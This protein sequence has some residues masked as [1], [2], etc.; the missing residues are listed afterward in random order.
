[1][2]DRYTIRYF[3]AVIDHGNFSKAAAHCHVSQPTLSVG[4]AKLERHLGQTLFQRSNRRVELTVAGARFAVHA[5]RVEAEFNHAERSVREVAS[6]VTIRLGILSTIPTRWHEALVE[7]L[8][9][10]VSTER[11]E[12]VEA[13]ERDVL[14]QLSRG[15]TDLALTIVRADN[16]RFLCEPL[17]TEDYAL[18]MS[19]DHPQAG[20]RSVAPGTLADNVM[21]ARRNCEALAETSRH[22]TA[23][24]VRPFFAAKTNNDDRALAL[25]RAGLGITVMPRSFWQ[26]D[27]AMPSLSGL[28]LTRTIGL[29]LAPH[30]DAAEMR[31][32]SIYCTI[33]RRVR[34]LA[35][36]TESAQARAAESG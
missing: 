24:G 36:E 12:F 9:P 31:A 30:V 20:E 26:A 10:A 17:F 3:L 29:L 19:L 2:I 18:A 28:A 34:A 14:D 25:V 6:Q 16:D 13:R 5:R 15:R 1:M 27:I 23:H 4:I 7:A 21:I 22:F 11:V 35:A 8:R 33:A 32:L